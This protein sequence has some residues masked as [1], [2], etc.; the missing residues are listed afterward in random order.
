[1]ATVAEVRGLLASTTVPDDLI[2]DLLSS[3]AATWLMGASAESVAMDLALCHP[4]LAQEEV[5][6]RV[7]TVSRPA[8][9]QLNLVAHDRPGLLA[10]TAGALALHGLSIEQASATTWPDRGLAVQRVTVTSPTT[11]IVP[12]WDAFGPD[13][14]AALGQGVR[15]EPRFVPVPPVKV[16]AAPDVGGRT[17][18]TVAAADT[19]GLLWAIASWLADHDC[20]IEL[21]AV[22]TTGSLARDTFVVV[23]TVDAAALA[24]AL[25]GP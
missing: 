3:A 16:T 10:R 12:D 5:R 21:A 8:H 25:G 6:A 15:H 24:T 23:G 14:R 13:L 2:D 20:N 18:V 9:W 7:E 11:D 17:A 4:P 22:E 1:M 19:I